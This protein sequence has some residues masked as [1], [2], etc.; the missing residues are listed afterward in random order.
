M[1]DT[2]TR[3]E[4]FTEDIMKS[5]ESCERILQEH[6][7][8]VVFSKVLPDEESRRQAA[9]AESIVDIIKSSLQCGNIRR[10]VRYQIILKKI[11]ANLSMS[12]DSFKKVLTQR[13]SL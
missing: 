6:E 7:G 2:D 9:C 5:L 1:D 4:I 12:Y 11:A 10:A 3:E 8:L 13:I